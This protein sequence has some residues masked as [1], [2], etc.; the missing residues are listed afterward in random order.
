MIE[1]ILYTC[2]Y[3]NTD[4]ADKDKA[5]ACE[6]NHKSI[7]K[8]EGVYKSYNSIPDGCPVKIRVKFEGNDKWIEYKR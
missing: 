2:Q 4:Y 3:C 6:E 1:K 7:A 8:I 5:I